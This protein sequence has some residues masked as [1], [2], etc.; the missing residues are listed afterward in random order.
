M[1]TGQQPPSTPQPVSRWAGHIA[2]SLWVVL[3]Q[4]GRFCTVIARG[5]GQHV[6]GE[7]SFYVAFFCPRG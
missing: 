2:F 6:S 3:Y 4:L 1:Q 7:E 5:G